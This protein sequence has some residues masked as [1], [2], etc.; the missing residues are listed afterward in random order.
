[1]CL[2]LNRFDR[3]DRFFGLL[4]EKDIPNEFLDE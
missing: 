2:Y 4:F 1:M 3:F